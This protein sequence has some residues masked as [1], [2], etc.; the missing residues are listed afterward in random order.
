M[1]VETMPEQFSDNE[2]QEN[3]HGPSDDSDR[4]IK[5]GQW[6]IMLVMI[7]RERNGSGMIFCL[8]ESIINIE[9]NEIVSN[10]V[11]LCLQSISDCIG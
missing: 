4:R 11:G 8:K 7:I 9:I 2:F 6:F 1:Y 5:F 10:T 3:V